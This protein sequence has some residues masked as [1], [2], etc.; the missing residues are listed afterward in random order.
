MQV[1]YLQRKWYI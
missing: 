1:E